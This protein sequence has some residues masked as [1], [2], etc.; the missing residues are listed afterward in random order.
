VKQLVKDFL[1]TIDIE[2]RIELI[3]QRL[4]ILEK[5]FGRKAKDNLG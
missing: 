3:E 5:A 4:A 1:M 2:K